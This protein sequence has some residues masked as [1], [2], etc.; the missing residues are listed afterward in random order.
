M[1]NTTENSLR[2]LRVNTLS[3]V[4]W[5]G[6]LLAA[7]AWILAWIFQW[8][9]GYITQSLAAFIGLLLV[10][11]PF[12]SQHQ[13]F[14][15]FGVANVVTLLRAGIAALFAGLIGHSIPRPEGA[16]IIAVLATAALVLD[17]MDGWLARR[18]GMASVFG[19]RFD[20]EVDAFFILILA[21]LV[22]QWGKAGAWV[23]LSGAMRYGFV[24]LS[25]GLPWLNGPL[26]RRRRR[27]TVCVIQA[28]V[29]GLCLTPPVVP[30]LST[31]LAGAALGLLA[32]SFVIDIG[33]L[34]RQNHLPSSTVP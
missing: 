17:G 6:L 9:S 14:T 29:L 27:Q 5:V 18:S 25:Y 15:R 32:L 30:P 13:P 26:P 2:R 16:W 33:W 4:T 7:I 22:W 10:L 3:W 20:M 11:A 23:I 19:A 34:W 24:A 31:V 28:I 21:V 1:A 12:L 8:P